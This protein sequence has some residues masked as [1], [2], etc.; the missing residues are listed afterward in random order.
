MQQ[1]LVGKKYYKEYTIKQQQLQLLEKDIKEML[2]HIEK[3]SGELRVERRP[4]ASFNEL[5]IIV[6]GQLT[7]IQSKNCPFIPRIYLIN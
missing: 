4:R 1:K 2:L 6:S 3:H 5:Q 7:K